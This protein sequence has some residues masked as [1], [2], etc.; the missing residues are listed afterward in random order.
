MTKGLYPHWHSVTRAPFANPYFG[1]HIERGCLRSPQ[2][3]NRSLRIKPGNGFKDASRTF[4]RFS[5]LK[6]DKHSR[7]CK[8][9][10]RTGR[11]FQGCHLMGFDLSHPSK[12]EA[13]Q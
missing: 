3:F 6:R 1:R 2:I 10:G 9:N 8:I 12:R 11:C 5:V 4:N 7:P 13:P